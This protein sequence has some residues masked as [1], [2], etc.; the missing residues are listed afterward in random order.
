MWPCNSFNLE[1]YFENHPLFT[2]K[3]VL[4]HEA[5]VKG[6]IP[7]AVSR[8]AQSYLQ[9]PGEGASVKVQEMPKVS[10][11]WVQHQTAFPKHWPHGALKGFCDLMFEQWWVT[12]TGFFI[13]LSVAPH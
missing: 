9:T 5:S 4:K 7:R 8:D 10:D 11:N 3:L 12:V 2:V 1:K 13:M 6:S